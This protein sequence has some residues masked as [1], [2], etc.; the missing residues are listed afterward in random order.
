MTKVTDYVGNWGV[1]QTYVYVLLFIPTFLDGSQSLISAFIYA[2]PNTRCFVPGV[3]SW[4]N[5]SYELPLNLSHRLYLAPMKVAGKDSYCYYCPN[6]TDGVCTKDRAMLCNHGFVYDRSQYTSTLLNLVC[7]Y[8]YMRD[9]LRALYMVGVLVG[10]LVLGTIS[11]KYHEISCNAQLLMLQNTAH[12]SPY[13]YGRKTTLIITGLMQLVIANSMPFCQNY[14]LFALLRTLMGVLGVGTFLCGFIIEAAYSKALPDVCIPGH[15]QTRKASDSCKKAHF[16][17]LYPGSKLFSDG[18]RFMTVAMELA[19]GNACIVA[20]IGM[21]MFWSVGA[22]Y[23]GLIAYLCRDWR[24]VQWACSIPMVIYIIFIWVLPESFRWLVAMGKTEKARKLMRTIVKVNRV[25]IPNA[26]IEDILSECT[27]EHSSTSVLE[28]FKH[29]TLFIMTMAMALSWAATTMAYYGLALNTSD[30]P[31]DDYIN[32]AIASVVD[33]PSYIL[34]IVLFAY[35]G[36][37]YS[38]IAMY[39]LGGIFCI[40]SGVMGNSVANLACGVIGKFFIS[41]SFAMIYN[42]TSE[43]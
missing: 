38:L 20:G 8:A 10:G 22:L 23:L 15:V 27:P 33:I 29:R 40:L 24:W 19:E 32:F 5:E 36:R 41:A 2:I 3:D 7:Q 17:S 31:G 6:V 21:Q 37:K 39:L 35:V 11:D 14:Y 4:D 43:I 34:A 18:P 25:H 13:R 30:L 1:Y 28:V 16:S 26:A 42:Y 12:D 9:L